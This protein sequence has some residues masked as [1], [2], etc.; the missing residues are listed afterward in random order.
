[1]AV[2]YTDPQN[3]VASKATDFTSGLA[4]GAFQ[5]EVNASAITPVLN[6]IDADGDVV[7][8]HFASALSGGDQTTLDGL[9]AAHVPAPAST[10]VDPAAL[11]VDASAEI[12]AITTKATP[13]AGDHLLIEDSAAS[14]EK[15]RVPWSALPGGGGGGKND[16]SFSYGTTAGP[17][18]EV[19]PSD[20]YSMADD[21]LFRGSDALG[22]PTLL[23]LLVSASTSDP[24]QWRIYDRTNS[25]EIAEGTAG[26]FSSVT[27]IDLG[28]LDN[29]PTGVSVWEVQVKEVPSAAA[30]AR[31]H[32]MMIGF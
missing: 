4:V 31:I 10:K 16:I 7:T 23:K 20:A 30:K 21:F 18:K 22:S 25:L 9:V 8:M 15:K 17:Y 28:V 3:P 19:T 5:D 11:H 32:A 6:S 29:I 1:M 24:L 12:S 2:N 13:V 27:L 26:D 14:N